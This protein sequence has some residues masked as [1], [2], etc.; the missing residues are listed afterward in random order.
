MNR[1][2]RIK[3]KYGLIKEKNYM[4][5]IRKKKEEYIYWQP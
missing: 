4:K 2:K 3:D 5:I 1:E